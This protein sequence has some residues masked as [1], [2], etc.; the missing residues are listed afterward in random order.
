MMQTPFVAP[1]FAED[2][3]F[4]STLVLANGTAVPTYADV[5]LRALDGKTVATQTI[6]FGPHSQQQVSIRTLREAG[7]V[8]NI[9]IGSVVVSQTPSPSGMTVLGAISITQRAPGSSRYIDQILAKPGYI[10]QELAMPTD[11]SSST[12]RSVADGS[13]GSPLVAITS[14]SQTVQ[15]VTAACLSADHVAPSTITLAPGQT[16]LI[17]VCDPDVKRDADLHWYA[18]N[19]PHGSNRPAGIELTSD[20]TSGSFAAYGL[21]PHDSQEGR[22]FSSVPFVDPKM[23]MS[24]TVVYTGV[25]VGSSTLLPAGIFTPV[26]SLANFSPSPRQVAVKYAL[27]RDGVATLSTIAK[28]T[29]AP[30]SS[31]EITLSGLN[32][33][34][35]LRDSFFVV[36]DGI[37]GGVG[38]KLVSKSSGQ[39]REV[40]L[41]A[42]DFDDSEN[43]GN[44]PWTVEDGT[45]ST[46]RERYPNPIL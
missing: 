39:L 2:G 37:P 34:P 18:E 5:T 40:E 16:V 9:T 25:P 19:L 7:S 20:G 22:Y 43:G 35:L 29:L 21:A 31:Q 33:D 13:D 8:P 46:L 27:T 1:I 26:L 41:L 45:T 44:H 11:E 36:S 14:L 6:Q 30:L 15:H 42:K 10:D 4:T 17:P 23:L 3:E 32:G 24:A 28:V 12:L 38:T